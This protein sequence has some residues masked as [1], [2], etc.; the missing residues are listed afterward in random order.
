MLESRI[1]GITQVGGLAGSAEYAFKEWAVS[2]Y[3]LQVN[4]RLV[5]CKSLFGYSRFQAFPKF[6]CQFPLKSENTVLFS[7]S[8]KHRKKTI[9]INAGDLIIKL[10][11]SIF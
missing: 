6:A 10:M 4:G 9:K 11:R 5:L 7:V 2:M 8:L 3:K 1:R